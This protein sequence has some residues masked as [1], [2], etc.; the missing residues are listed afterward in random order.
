MDES[1]MRQFWFEKL[2]QSMTPPLY[3][4]PK[5]NT[6]CCDYSRQASDPTCRGYCEMCRKYKIK[7]VGSTC[8]SQVISLK[9]QKQNLNN[10][11]IKVYY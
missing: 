3:M 11:E 7:F 2:P 5:K 8:S 10:L 1:I 4:F 6:E 9:K